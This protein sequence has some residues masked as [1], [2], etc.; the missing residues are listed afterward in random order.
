MVPNELCPAHGHIE[1]QLTIAGFRLTLARYAGNSRLRR[2]VHQFPGI[3]YL[4]EGGLE[5][6]F[7]R[8]SISCAAGTLLV[9]HHEDDHADRFAPE[10][11]TMIIVENTESSAGL[12]N[13]GP[14]PSIIATP[15]VRLLGG[16]LASLI[17]RNSKASDLALCSHA[18]DL[19]N[20]AT[21]PRRS[22]G[23]PRTAR[24][25]QMIHD[26]VGNIR[27]IGTLAGRVGV[28]PVSLARGFR[29]QFGCSV[30]AYVLRVRVE[31]ALDQVRNTRK[32][33]AEIAADTGFANQSHMTRCF[34]KRF[35][36]SPGSLRKAAAN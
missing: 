25:V 35:G 2:H 24:A 4:A 31:R 29:E 32:A 12:P 18:V 16:A 30:A 20:A 17:P 7:A 23:W 28:H 5:E 33:L 27:Q 8:D 6:T 15:H 36:F 10:G 9:R 11:A 13:I 34:V 1:A 14:R 19:W 26:D 21:S 3:V 22:R